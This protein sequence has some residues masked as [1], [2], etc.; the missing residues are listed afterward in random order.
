[1]VVRSVSS[2]DGKCRIGTWR[3]GLHV[4]TSNI[5][6]HCQR[7]LAKTGGVWRETCPYDDEEREWRENEE[8]EREKRGG[9]KGREWSRNMARKK[10]GKVGRQREKKMTKPF[11]AHPLLNL[12]SRQPRFPALHPRTKLNSNASPPPW[13]QPPPPLG[14][15]DP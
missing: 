9:E 4:M 3:L 8:R 10:G 15:V 6:S 14:W 11:R 1:M 12:M 13:H 7:T 2:V 5:R